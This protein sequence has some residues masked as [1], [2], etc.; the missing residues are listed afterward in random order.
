MKILDN[1]LA[2]PMIY[3]GICILAFVVGYILN[4]YKNNEQ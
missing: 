1:Y 4:K 3:F 2:F